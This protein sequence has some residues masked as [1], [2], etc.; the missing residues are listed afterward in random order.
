MNTNLNNPRAKLLDKLFCGPR[1]F[2][3]EEM[4][5]WQ[6]FHRG[7]WPHDELLPNYQVFDVGPYT[8]VAGVLVRCSKLPGDY[9]GLVYFRKGIE[10][11]IQQA[12]RHLSLSD[13]VALLAFELGTRDTATYYYD[14]WPPKYVE[15][16]KMMEMWEVSKK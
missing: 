3:E 4:A 1:Q 14:T 5:K 13:V 6:Q 16:G 7:S 12:D 8:V 15:D 11:H 2:T 9:E 10:D